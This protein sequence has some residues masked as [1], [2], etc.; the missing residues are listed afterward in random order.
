MRCLIWAAVSSK[1]QASEEK[2]SIPSQVKAARELIQRNDG[3]HEVGEP[4]VIPGHSRSYIFL[5]DAAADMP[6]YS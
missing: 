5:A 6:V 3:W 2:D 4:L 1:P